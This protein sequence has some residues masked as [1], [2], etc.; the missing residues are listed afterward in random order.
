MMKTT[1]GQH[2]TDLQILFILGHTDRELAIV[3]IRI[4]VARVTQSGVRGAAAL[5]C[6]PGAYLMCS[7]KPYPRPSVS[8][9]TFDKI[10]R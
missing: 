3:H 10:P 6:H 7:L 1:G 4:A 5:A 9:P 8:E 2:F